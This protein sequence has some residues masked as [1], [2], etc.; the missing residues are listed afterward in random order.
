M[1]FTINSNVLMAI[2]S[3][4]ALVELSRHK[5]DSFSYARKVTNFYFMAAVSLNLT[6]VIVIFFLAPLRFVNGENGFNMFLNDMFFFH[7]VN[8]I[9]SAYSFLYLFNGA[10]INK[11]SRLLCFIPPMLYASVYATYV[12]ILHDW[13]DF[14]NFTFGGNYWLAA[15]LALVSITAIYT[16][17][18]IFA[19]AY[20][21][22]LLKKS[23]SKIILPSS[24]VAKF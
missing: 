9:L 1:P 23:S 4:I 21:R 18:T 10:K 19:N 24:A 22:R 5:N 7:L 17:A 2:A 11:T 8:P 15:V 20:N 6:A 13:E 14:Y 3:A 16:I 12:L